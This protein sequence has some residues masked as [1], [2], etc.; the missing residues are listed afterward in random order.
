MYHSVLIILNKGT[1]THT[2][3]IIALLTQDAI[4]HANVRAIHK[5]LIQR[6]DL[7][8]RSAFY[9]IGT[10]KWFLLS[11]FVIDDTLIT[12]RRCTQITTL[13]DLLGGCCSVE[14]QTENYCKDLIHTF[15]IT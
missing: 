2:I 1:I 11:L 13:N 4:S 3:H 14:Q 12:V 10:V 6:N 8:V 15:L 5:P 9:A 7:L